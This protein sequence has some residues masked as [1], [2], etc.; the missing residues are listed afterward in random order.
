MKVLRI[1][2]LS[3]RSHPSCGG[4]GVYIQAL[5]KYLSEI[6]HKVTVISGSPY[7]SLDD[8]VELIKLP[9]FNLMEKRR[10][11]PEQE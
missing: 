6:G 2:L 7:P 11:F 1:C 3:Y 10:F 8:R 4:Q 9:G 5:S